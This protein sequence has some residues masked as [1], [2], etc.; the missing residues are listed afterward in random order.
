MCGKIRPVNVR[1]RESVCMHEREN[2]T[3]RDRFGARSVSNSLIYI[4][5]ITVTSKIGNQEKQ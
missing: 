4:L 5:I 3:D 2:A 1:K